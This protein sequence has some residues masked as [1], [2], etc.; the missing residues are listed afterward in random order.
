[1]GRIY[2]EGCKA[3]KFVAL[4]D[5]DWTRPTTGGVF[6][7]HPGA[8]QYRDCRQMFDKEEKNF[9]ALIIAVPDHWHAIMLM[10]AMRMKKHIYCAKPIAHSIGELRKIRQGLNV[11]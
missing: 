5:L 1:M 7:V 10:S 2:I 9:D 3:E 11:S 4:C 6:D 8:K